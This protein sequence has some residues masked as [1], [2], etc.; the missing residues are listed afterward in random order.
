ILRPGISNEHAPLGDP[1][2][3]SDGVRAVL[4][5]SLNIPDRCACFGVERDETAVERSH[6]DAA[7]IERDA[8]IDHIA[9][10]ELRVVLRHMRI[11]L[12]ELMTCSRIKRVYQAPS[13]RRVEDTVLNQWRRFESAQSSEIERPGEAQ[14]AYGLLVDLL[15]MA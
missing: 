4:R 9:A 3:A 5:R 8:A 1:G 10:Y 7:S 2:R 12:P 14:P 11:V 15:E 6:I 13:A